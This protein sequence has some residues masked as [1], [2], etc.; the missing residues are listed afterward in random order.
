MDE[1]TFSKDELPEAL[2]KT[3]LSYLPL[4]GAGL[5]K[6]EMAEKLCKSEATVNTHI[7]NIQAKLHAKNGPSIVA[8]AFAHGL[9]KVSLS[10]FLFFMVTLGDD[11]VRRPSTARRAESQ[12]LQSQG[13]ST[14]A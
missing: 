14:G 8:R 1:L 12:Y 5:T 3:E 2:S 9:L 6:K 10:A 11:D 13:I 4:L 7:K